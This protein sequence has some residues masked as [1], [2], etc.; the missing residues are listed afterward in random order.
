[1]AKKVYIEGNPRPAHALSD[2]AGREDIKKG[3]VGATR[4]RHA[5]S[6]DAHKLFE[7]SHGKTP[8]RPGG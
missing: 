8:A 5:L 6:A 1:V 3:G 4:R 7:K 2:L